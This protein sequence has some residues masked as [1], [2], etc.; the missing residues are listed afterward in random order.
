MLRSTRAR[1]RQRTLDGA[2]EPSDAQQLLSGGTSGLRLRATIGAP[3]PDYP[4]PGGRVDYWQATDT[5]TSSPWMTGELGD[6]KHDANFAVVRASIG[7]S[8][9]SRC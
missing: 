5:A 8:P 4:H 7:S 6:H 3:G 1:A 9:I 2:T